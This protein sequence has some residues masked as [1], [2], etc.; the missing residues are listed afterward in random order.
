MKIAVVGLGD[1]AEKA[2]LP[3]LTQF[4][5]VE[6]VFCTRNIERL[7]QLANK[8]RI[9]E[10]YTDYKSL[11]NAN[12]DAVM[13][14]S[15]TASHYEIAHFFLNVGIPVFVDKPLASTYKECEQ[16]HDFAEQKQ[17]PLFL[18]F[19]RR[20]IPLY[21]QH[22]PTVTAN[23]SETNPLL[24][25]RWEKN[26]HNLVGDARTFIF[27]DFIHPLDSI[28]V[29]GSVSED[30]LYI[31]SQC[32]QLSSTPTKLARLDVQWQQEGAIFHAS[33]NR[34]Y[35][36]TNEVISA[37]YKNTS[38]RF[39]SFT[40]GNKWQDNSHEVVRLADWTPMLAAKGFQGMAEHWLDVI[41]SGKQMHSVT[42]RNLH[43]HRLAEIIYQKVLTKID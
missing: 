16:L 28:N 27:D 19:N 24:S 22:L 38:F 11:V 7:K 33:M 30:D 17:Q 5:E 29:Y 3:I 31:T 9:Q 39:D 42:M 37:S 15:A 26:R 23:V 21:Q 13:I 41:R 32:D 14:H 34:L 35:G 43:S 2:H 6:L 25:L 36:V 20:Y 8:Y 10:Y 4:E 40:E 1:I 18:G 12:I